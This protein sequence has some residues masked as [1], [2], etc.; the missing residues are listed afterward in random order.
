VPN[1]HSGSKAGSAAYKRGRAK[2]KHRFDTA[3]ET[4]FAMKTLSLLSLVAGA[5]LLP[6]MA[7]AQTAGARGGAGVSWGGGARAGGGV[8]VGGG[9]RGGHVGGGVRMGGGRGHFQGGGHFRGGQHFRGGRGHF[10]GGFGGGV[11]IPRFRPGHG[12]PR[13]LRRGGFIHPFWF[14]PQFYIQNW[15][16]YGFADPGEDRRW[17]RYYDDAYLIDQG[18]RV[19]DSREGLDW[20][21]Y[22]ERWETED[23]IPSYYGRNEYQPGEE[24]YAYVEEQGAE[25]HAEARGHHRR[26]ERRHGG[27]YEVEHRAGG[28]YAGG[29]GHGHGGP[30][31]MGPG[32]PVVYGGGGHTT[33]QVYGGGYGYGMYA[34]PII[35][36]TT[37]TTAGASAGYTEEVIEEVIETR[38]RARRRPRGCNCSRPRPPAGERG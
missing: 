31:P 6:T 36:E 12:F 15:Q 8:H 30:M 27:G 17:V 19:V 11:H 24:D 23:G 4:G 34:Y 18:G 25:R 22:G 2:G 7:V 37:T 9:M 32:G 28:A 21:Q 13:R 38:Q 20:D 3:V 14:G 10:R 16:G 5:A 33:T 1:W 26:D 29:Y 35:I